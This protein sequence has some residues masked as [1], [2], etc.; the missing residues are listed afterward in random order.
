MRHAAS[1]VHSLGLIARRTSDDFAHTEESL[2]LT[3]A[4]PFLVTLAS[5]VLVDNDLGAAPL[6]NNR[7]YHASLAK[8]WLSDGDL[9]SFTDHQHRGDLNPI[10]SG[11]IEFFNRNQVPL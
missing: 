10:S 1:S 4:L 7:T 6:P 3:M 5:L 9:V 2:P 8:L 11:T